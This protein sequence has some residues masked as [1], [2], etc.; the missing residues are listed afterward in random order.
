[1]HKGTFLGEMSRMAVLSSNPDNYIH[2]LEDL[3]SIYIAHSYLPGLISKWTKDN[4][5]KRWINCLRET[6]SDDRMAVNRPGVDTSNL[7]ILK[8]VFNPIWDK[9][10]VHELAEVVVDHWLSSLNNW[11][12]YNKQLFA[13]VKEM[14]PEISG[15]VSWGMAKK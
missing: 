13:Y 11:G 7:L 6:T 3:Q 8:I 12:W 1:V 5:T 9:F 10:N 14:Y 15:N 2:A 4:I